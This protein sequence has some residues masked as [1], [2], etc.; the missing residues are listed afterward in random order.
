MNTLHFA[1]ADYSAHAGD[2]DPELAD[3]LRDCGASGDASGAV[4]YVLRRYTVT[5]DPSDCAAYLR[6]FGAWDDD[7]LTDHAEN[8]RRLV[9]LAGCDLREQSEIY[10]CTY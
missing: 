5:G 9:W 3:D 6:R 1:G 4:D 10:F 8:L 7:E 2:L